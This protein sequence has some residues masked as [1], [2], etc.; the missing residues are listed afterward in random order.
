MPIIGIISENGKSDILEMIF[1]RIPI[2]F[3]DFNLETNILTMI[4]RIFLKMPIQK[5]K[6][7]IVYSK[8]KKSCQILGLE[9]RPKRRINFKHWK[10]DAKIPEIKSNYIRE[11]LTSTQYAQETMV[12]CEGIKDDLIFIQGGIPSKQLLIEVATRLA[13]NTWLVV[14]FYKKE[15]MDRVWGCNDNKLFHTTDFSTI[16]REYSFISP[17]KKKIKDPVDSPKFWW[18]IMHLMT[19]ENASKL[20]RL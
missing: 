2:Q 15:Q 1:E 14:A 11:I 3:R 5:K 8:N 18:G 16:Q 4:K 19:I 12:Y 17:L 20:V 13:K 9:R 10:I 7:E 6:K